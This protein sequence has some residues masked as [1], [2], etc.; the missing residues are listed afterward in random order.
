MTEDLT[1]AES[2][3][4][5]L[6]PGDT[7]ELLIINYVAAV[8]DETPAPGTTGDVE[9]AKLYCTD[10]DLAG[11]VEFEV[12]GPETPVEA[13]GVTAQAANVE[14][15]NCTPG[16][17]EFEIFAFGDKTSEP[18]L[19]TVGSDGLIVIDDVI[20]VTTDLSPHKLKEVSTG[21]EAQFDVADGAVTKLIVINYVGDDD[22]GAGDDSGD[23]GDDSKDDGGD[24]GD[25]GGDDQKDD[26]TSGG[27]ASDDAK[28]DGGTTGGGGATTLPDTGAG[29]GAERSRLR[30]GRCSWSSAAW[31]RR[32]SACG[33]ARPNS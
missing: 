29:T 26:G 12:L 24:T 5:V 1:G 6:T 3:D 2:V 33:A 14:A 4:I 18:I 9:I 13:T 28:D 10:A 22:G 16:A 11:Q 15:D 32:A 30:R 19:V 8:V 20:P 7:A 25:T 23:T 21:A 17:A 31:R 27:G